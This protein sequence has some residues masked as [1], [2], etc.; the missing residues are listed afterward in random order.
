MDL[1]IHP[2]ETNIAFLD[3]ASG[4]WAS[5]SGTATIIGNRN[6]V[7][8]YYSPILRTWLGDLGDGVHDGGPNDP[9][10]GLIRL[11][12]RIST[13]LI[14]RKGIVGTAT[15]TIKSAV[16]GNVPQINSIRELSEEELSECTFLV[17]S[18]PFP[19]CIPSC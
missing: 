2:K 16:K 4:S 18:F 9:R 17:F 10:I 13:Y 6:A 12:A 19:G 15:E 8:K 11:E 5:I 7:Q 1:S 14:A 3:P